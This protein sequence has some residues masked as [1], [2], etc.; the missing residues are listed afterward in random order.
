MNPCSSLSGLCMFTAELEVHLADQIH[1]QMVVA[2][3]LALSELVFL[4]CNLSV[5]NYNLLVDVCI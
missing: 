1:L 4:L 2:L 5:T 3:F